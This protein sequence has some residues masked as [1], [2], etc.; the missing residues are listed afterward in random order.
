[1][2]T[3]LDEIR[4]AW[5]ERCQAKRLLPGTKGRAAELGSFMSGLLT[6]LTA[7]RVMPFERAAELASL[8]KSGL[9]EELMA[10]TERDHGGCI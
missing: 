10:I 9:G 4:R 5:K 6:G 8:V 3:Y 2:E 1:M 7:S